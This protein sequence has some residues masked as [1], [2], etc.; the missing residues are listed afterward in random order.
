[1]PQLKI[2]AVLAICCAAAFV[3]QFGTLFL[4]R[5]PLVVV[6]YIALRRDAGERYWCVLAGL[7]VDT[8]AED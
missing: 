8:P 2:A 4:H 3:A 6:V 1:M 7:I 5:L